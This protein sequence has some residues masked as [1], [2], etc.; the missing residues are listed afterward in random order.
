MSET[1]AVEGCSGVTD[2][3]AGQANRYAHGS[4]VIA[5]L[6]ARAIQNKIEAQDGALNATQNDCD[7]LA[8]RRWARFW[9]FND[10]IEWIDEL[11]E[12]EQTQCEGTKPNA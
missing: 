8:C 3:P 7:D 1:N 6:R 12:C 4:D 9:A 10:V 5:E 2:T 11:S